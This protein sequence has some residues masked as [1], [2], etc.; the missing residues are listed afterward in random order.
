MTETFVQG[1]YITALGMGL[2]FFS[3]GILMLTIRGLT[4]VF[5]PRPQT[6]VAAPAA[7]AASDHRALAA[8]IGLALALAEAADDA[9]T[10]GKAPG[11]AA[12]GH[13]QQV[14]VWRRGGRN[15]YWLPGR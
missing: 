14:N 6:A 11:R 5:R 8:A 9:G 15:S 3:L 10:Q 7:P 12:N 1:L 4:W 13:G 2:V